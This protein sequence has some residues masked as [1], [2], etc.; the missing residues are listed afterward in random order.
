MVLE[1]YASFKFK[2]AEN[3]LGD[4]LAAIVLPLIAKYLQQ[5]GIESSS[6]K[7]GSGCF[8]INCQVRDENIDIVV[9][10]P[11]VLRPGMGGI[12]IIRVFGWWRR[13]FTKVTRTEG[14]GL[15]HVCEIVRDAVSA[16]EQFEQLNWM[17]F[18]E[19]FAWVNSWPRAPKFP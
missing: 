6:I 13:T 10:G 16:D 12:E 3:I 5:R 18:N 4:K 15:I 11:P 2:G 8:Y 19:W 9:Y 14:E 17:T 7:Q 1:N